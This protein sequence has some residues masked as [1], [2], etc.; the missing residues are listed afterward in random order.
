MP[1]MSASECYKVLA[2]QELVQSSDS[3]FKIPD[4]KI[5][6]V[7]LKSGFTV[8]NVKDALDTYSPNFVK[9][10]VESK[11]LVE[12]SK[13]QIINK[14][15]AKANISRSANVKPDKSRDSDMSR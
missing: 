8:D 7:M 11:I 1:G 13:K 10:G 12:N 5:V 15:N 4:Q 2:K 14:E 6:D 3:S 9:K